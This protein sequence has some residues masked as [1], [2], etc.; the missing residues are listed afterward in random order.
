MNR[1]IVNLNSDNF[2][3][4][5]ISKAINYFQNLGYSDYEISCLSFIREKKD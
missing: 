5:N 2:Y 3:F 1:I 4:D